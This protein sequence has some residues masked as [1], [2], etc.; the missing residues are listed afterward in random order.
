MASDAKRNPV[1]APMRSKAAIEL[2]II[3]EHDAMGRAF[4]L[5][6]DFRKI[7]TTADRAAMRLLAATEHLT[8]EPHEAV[9]CWNG[10]ARR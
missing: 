3:A 4:D 5:V 7:A 8:N 9:P 10:C 6:R 1:P 2:A